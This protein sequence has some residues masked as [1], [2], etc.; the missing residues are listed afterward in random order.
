MTKRAAPVGFTYTK[1]LKRLAPAAVA[2]AACLSLLL[3]GSWMNQ[4]EWA[5]GWLRQRY[6]ALDL[7]P[8]TLWMGL[9]RVGVILALCSVEIAVHFIRRQ[10]SKNA[11]ENRSA[12]EKATWLKR[13]NKGVKEGISSAFSCRTFAMCAVQAAAIVLLKLLGAGAGTL[14]AALFCV[15]GCFSYRDVGG[16]RW[17]RTLQGAAG[18]VYIGYAFA[19]WSAFSWL[20]ALWVAAA[21]F[22][23]TRLALFAPLTVEAA[24][25]Q[26]KEIVKDAVK[27]WKWLAAFAGAAAV[28]IWIGGSLE[29]TV[30]WLERRYERHEPW[31]FC[32]RITVEHLVASL[33]LLILFYP[34]KSKIE[35]FKNRLDAFLF[36]RKAKKKDVHSEEKADSKEKP[37]KFGTERI[38][39]L[40]FAAVFVAPIGETIAL[41][42]LIIAPLSALGADIGTQTVVS[43]LLF[44]LVHWRESPVKGIAAGLPGGVYLGFTFAFWYPQ[45]V[46]TALW[47]TALSHA[48][49]NLLTPVAVLPFG[50]VAGLIKARR[51]MHK[52]S[53]KNDAD[54]QTD[55]A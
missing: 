15:S 10:G 46:W 9:E 49:G 30:G 52:K 13:L 14:A 37:E 47:V 16:S 54:A 7:L 33:V 19:H 21:L 3:L 17:V 53:A 2:V 27:N 42:A 40:I 11:K 6:D 26:I 48:L 44:A 36:D 35:A 34:F 39:N 51:K 55:E 5:V 12:P 25:S 41:Q 4:H 45:S 20:S 28:W 1:L 22:A 31:P 38:V 18:G 32:W 23:A 43:A 29:W 8:F 50:V 24:A